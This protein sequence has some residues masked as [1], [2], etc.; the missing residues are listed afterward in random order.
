VA[1]VPESVKKLVAAGAEVGVEAGAGARAGF[2]DQDYEA[3]GA[4]VM[5]RSELLPEADILVCVNRPEEADF[6]A[7]KSGAVII[8]FLKP[9][10]E[11]AALEPVI[12]RKLTAFAVELVPRTTRA[13]SMDALSSMATIAGYKAMIIAAERLPRM[14][15]L[16]M[17]AAGTVPPAKVL[18]LGAGVAG[19]QAIAT[20][21]RLGAVVS[22]YDV[23]P[24]SADE[25]R[26]MG[27]TFV[28]IDLEAVEG[29]GG[30]AR[31]LSA[32]RA[33]RQQELLA[34]YVADADVLVTTAA[35]P[36]R[37]APVLVTAAMLAAMKPGGVVVDLA[38][39]SGGNVEGARPG[40]DLAVPVSGGSVRLVGMKDAASTM[41]VDASRLYAKNVANLLLLMTKDGA[42][43]PDFDDEVVAGTC[44]THAGEVRHGPTA[45]LLG[46]SGIGG[47]AR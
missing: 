39:E 2:S 1:L 9:L 33:V 5:V 28:T 31:E 8:G 10:D 15:P 29:A 35:V 17:T 32:D 44:L 46:E 45:Q 6:P 42:V 25:V 4:G 23:R 12:A 14:F 20:A 27:G 24:A 47:P 16:L 21:K 13:Q 36:G 11:P 40:E 22:A 19:L 38:A 30:Y 34:P 26:S 37:R 3:A 18:V 43:T 41:P 7:L